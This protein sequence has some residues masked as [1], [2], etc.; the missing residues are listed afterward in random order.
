MS[1]DFCWNFHSGTRAVVTGGSR[2]IGAAIVEELAKKGAK[3]LTCSRSGK[4]LKEKLEI[5]EGKGY[6][7]E[8]V[9]ADLSTVYGRFA[10]A[11]VIRR[12]LGE[13]QKLDILVNN[14]GEQ[15]SNAISSHGSD[16]NAMD[17][18]ETAWAVNFHSMFVLTNIC[19][20]FM[21]RPGTTT[22]MAPTSSVVNIAS[23]IG[24]T[25]LGTN[26]PYPA[27]KAAAIK[28]TGDWA[29][30]WG[31][32]GIRVNCVAPWLI[33]NDDD[34]TQ[35]DTMEAN[36]SNKRQDNGTNSSTLDQNPLGRQGQAMEVAGLVTFLCLPT[37]GFISGQVICVDGGYSRSEYYDQATAKKLREVAED[38]ATSRDTLARLTLPSARSMDEFC[39]VLETV[40]TADDSIASEI[41]DNT[42]QQALEE[43][44]TAQIEA[45][46]S[47]PDT[48]WEELRNRRQTE[49]T[50]TDTRW[51]EWKSRRQN[52]ATDDI[53]E[54]RSRQRK[55]ETGFESRD[56]APADSSR[57]G[58]EEHQP[59]QPNAVEA[60][61]DTASAL[62]N[63][64]LE[65]RIERAERA[66]RDVLAEPDKFYALQSGLRRAE[67]TRRNAPT[68]PTSGALQSRLNQI[69]QARKGKNV[70][71]Q[72]PQ[73]VGVQVVPTP[74]IVEPEVVD[75]EET[76]LDSDG[77]DVSRV[78]A[79]RDRLKKIKDKKTSRNNLIEK[80]K[81]LRCVFSTKSAKD[82]T[83]PDFFNPSVNQYWDL[84]ANLLDLAQ[85]DTGEM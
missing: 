20:E 80:S 35:K 58:E 22:G 56:D 9:M 40:S 8:G 44:P 47:T 51:E 4:G 53:A 49:T 3:V 37:A 39:R 70:S 83:A 30:E 10:F 21:K 79:F 29:C 7:V 67:Q 33:I 54:W 48:K 15:P 76:K 64:A 68:P 81:S 85:K 28:A 16:C 5:W 73:E 32:D 74:T 2:N 36:N 6:D 61:R 66:I 71:W 45:T 31:P 57:R 52:S 62:S 27:A 38:I 18:Q 50:L 60:K 41:V 65:S 34:T 19:K 77:L 59:E 25:K 17:K 11:E 75:E 72:H 78:K 46:V 69:G 24:L 13:D 14:V 23:V 1:V 26:D 12:W 84:D 82:S 42:P 63:A 43:S 55:E